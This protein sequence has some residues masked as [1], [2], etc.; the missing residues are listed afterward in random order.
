MSNSEN[1]SSKSSRDAYDGTAPAS[2]KH[3]YTPPVLVVYG[4]VR[5]LTRSG[6]GTGTDGGTGT[7]QMM[8]DRNVKEEVVKIGDHP[9]GI[10]LYLFVYKPEYR[11]KCGCG[12]QFGVMAD[13][14][15][16]VMP[17]AVSVHPDGYKVVDYAMLGISRD[18]H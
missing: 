9:L 15:E 14:V 2:P 17:E 3:A 1:A 7:M 5:D 13:E 11:D 8:S 12:R 10:G 18:L 16:Q 6:Q 4:A